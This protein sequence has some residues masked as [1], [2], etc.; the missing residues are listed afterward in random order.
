MIIIHYHR[1]EGDYQ[2]WHLW[3]W[4]EP[5]GAPS[6]PILPTGSD[7]FGAV[8]PMDP[9]RFG[10]A[11]EI[12]IIPRFGEWEAKDGGDRRI[13]MIGGKEYWLVAGDH[14]LYTKRPD[15]S[16]FIERVFIDDARTLSVVLSRS[17]PLVGLPLDFFH[18]R[19][20]RKDLVIGR[21][22]AAPRS[23]GR[24][25][26]FQVVL[27]ETLP[28]DPKK[29][30][31]VNVKARGFRMAKAELRKVLDGPRFTWGGPLGARVARGKTTFHVYAPDA[32]SM[33]VLLAR[34]PR[35]D[36]E[37]RLRMKYEDQGVF[38]ARAQEDLSG[39]YYR[40]RVNRGGKTSDLLDPYSP[41]QAGWDGWSLVTDPTTITPV[42]R[43]SALPMEPVDAIVYEMH[44]R[45]F[46]IDPASG[47]Q[48][49]GKY[50]GWTE[51]GTKLTGTKV[52]T[53]VDHLVELGV[54][55]VQVLPVQ[56]FAHDERSSDYN[57]GYMPAHYF[58]VEGWF[59]SDPLGQVRQTE[60]KALVDSL[61]ARGI[62]VVVDVVYNHTAE[63][64]GHPVSFLGLAPWYY[65]RTNFAGQFENGSGCGNE[66]RTEAPM[67]RR[68]ILDS[69]RY[70]V[71]TYGVDGFRFDLMG[72]MDYETMLS[73]VKEL[74]VL[75]PDIL[76]WGEPWGGGSSSFSVHG[77]GVQR[78]AGFA[79]FNDTFRN[80]LKGSVW[81]L[82]PGYV[83]D[84]R[85]KGKVIT[86]IKGSID[87]FADGPNETM[88]YLDCHDNRTFFDRLLVSTGCRDLAVL[89]AMNKLGAAIIFT[90]QGVPFIHGG[91]EM[92]RSKGGHHNSYN[93]PDSVNMVRWENKQ[94]Y[95]DVVKYYQG[96]I[97]MRK[98]HPIFRL[99]TAAEIRRQLHF[100]DLDLR[101]PL[102]GAVV[103]YQLLRGNTADEWSEAVVIFNPHG[104]TASVKLPGK[105][106]RIALDGKKY[107][108]RGVLL[109]RKTVDSVVKVPPRSA[110]VLF[111]K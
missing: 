81:D 47:I 38:S 3:S 74:R 61:H 34:Q 88:N 27:R 92:L 52:K 6:G 78:G 13:P 40:Y 67:C 9:R 104:K 14:A 59:A 35:G 57:W 42:T 46:T 82:D 39:W 16:P 23:D 28:M 43:A 55:V 105:G 25:R 18:V 94:K 70:F 53:G 99:H 1:P 37:R 63:G 109:R 79:V 44:I 4:G 66:L 97:A 100:L 60:F 17:V 71:E 80:A 83:V 96:L 10:H 21:V 65:Y 91:Q 54:N 19:L 26:I 87:D 98:A 50:S 73:L 36:G 8:Y 7:D 69:L 58:S 103:A 77:K 85:E 12:G 93:Q 20:G 107:H 56:T 49:R 111:K 51:K 5:G 48:G 30:L 62:R 64:S 41:V 90:S 33:E 68:M 32:G 72:L 84:G 75:K 2:G 108:P 22:D 89:K 95:A 24:A 31:T 15:T 45:D 106:Y 11:Q 101:I 29:L 86:G 102:P 76:L 110:M